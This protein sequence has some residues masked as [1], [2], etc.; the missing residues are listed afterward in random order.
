MI[1][2]LAHEADGK[3]VVMLGVDPQNLSRLRDGQPIRVN[4]RNLI[5]GGEPIEELPD[6]DVVVFFAGAEEVVQLKGMLRK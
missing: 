6:L 5:P 2:S 4:L 1:R 3:Q